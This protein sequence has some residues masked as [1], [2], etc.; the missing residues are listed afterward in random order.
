MHLNV[1]TNVALVCGVISIYKQYA[2]LL[3]MC[4][5]WFWGI[6]ISFTMVRVLDDTVYTR[7]MEKNNWSPTLF[8][9]GN[10]VLHVLPFLATVLYTPC[11]KIT[12]IHG[13]S[14]SSLFY[15]WCV[16]MSRGTLDLSDMY[17]YLPQRVWRQC[18]HTMVL[19]VLCTPFV[20]QSSSSSTLTALA[21]PSSSR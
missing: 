9:T 21:L 17:V 15:V 18:I 7:M 5:C 20:F 3:A 10:F 12:F 14:A 13:I 19:I 2:F 8:H 6:M 16:V 11:P 4:Y 1:F